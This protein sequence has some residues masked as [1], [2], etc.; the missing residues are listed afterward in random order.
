MMLLMMW[1][2]SALNTTDCLHDCSGNGACVAG[3]CQCNVDKNG[4]GYKGDDCSVP[5][6]SHTFTGGGNFRNCLY[7]PGTDKLIVA[8]D[9]E[10]DCFCRKTT[11][12][13]DDARMHKADMSTRKQ[14]FASDS[15]Y[16]C[17][18]GS[19]AC[20]MAPFH[21]CTEVLSVRCQFGNDPSCA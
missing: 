3:I 11:G 12:F 17:T 20:H 19:R 4:F 2:T 14:T 6:G 10:A 8:D 18:D 7:V 16:R 9:S 15:T 1:V 5:C 13:G 21:D